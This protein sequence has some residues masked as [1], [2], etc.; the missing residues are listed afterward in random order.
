[1]S[2]DAIWQLYQDKLG[3]K[4]LQVVIRRSLLLVAVLPWAVSGSIDTPS[5]YQWLRQF[6]TIF[7]IHDKLEAQLD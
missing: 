5:D 3:T 2:G 1:M 7:C 6:V 4:P